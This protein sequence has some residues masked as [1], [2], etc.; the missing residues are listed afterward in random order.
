VTPCPYLSIN[1]GDLRQKS[2]KEIWFNSEVLRLL[3]DVKNLKG[4][5]GICK[6]QEMCGGCR[7]RAYGHSNPLV[8]CG[9]LTP[10]SEISGDYLDE[11]PF[12]T[13]NPKEFEGD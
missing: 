10:S 13:Y 1:V 4:R 6:Y 3:R 8:V 9:G 2:F 11:D 7:A 12:C 5:C